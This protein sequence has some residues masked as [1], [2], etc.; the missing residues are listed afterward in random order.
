MNNRRLV[1]RLNRRIEIQR[2]SNIED[3]FG[4]FIET[5]TAL[6]EVWAEIKPIN[7]FE[8]FEANSIS[9]KIT[10]TIILRYFADLKTEHRIKYQG[11]IFVIKGI[12]NVLE[13]NKVLELKVEE[14]L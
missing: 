2:K 13:E 12:I 6:K 5:W 11:R 1:D 10:H 7:T 4:G 9:E 14:T 8:H 3:G